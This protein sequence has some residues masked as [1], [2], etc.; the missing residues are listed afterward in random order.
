MSTV[1]IIIS[2]AVLALLLFAS[3]RPGTFE[4]TRSTTINAPA[5]MVYGFLD[6]F[7]QFGAWSPWEKLDPA[8]E[9]THSGAARGVGAIYQWVGNKKVGRGR[10]EILESVPP[11]QLTIKLDFVEPFESHNTTV[12]SL[13]SAAG[14]TKVTWRM[15]GP[16]T[17]MSK[18]MSIFV[19]M[20]KMVGKDFE[21]GLA[22]LKAAAER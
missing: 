8:M 3:T 22:N 16:N 21:T 11:K 4:V 2:V 6:D 18:V 15:F 9:R 1:L 17:F 10:M 5:D 19:S 20:D 13:D 12:F 7:H 14:A